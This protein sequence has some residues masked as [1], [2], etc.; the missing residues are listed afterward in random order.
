[1]QVSGPISLLPPLTLTNISLDIAPGQLAAVANGTLSDSP[2]AVSLTSTAVQT[3]NSS[4]YIGVVQLSLV[5][6]VSQGTGSSG[7]TLH[8]LLTS[9]S[10]SITSATGIQLP[11]VPG[12]PANADTSTNA[13][14]KAELVYDSVHGLRLVK[15]SLGAAQMG[16]AELARRMGIDWQ[17]GADGSVDP[18]T[19]RAPSV[20][21]ALA[22]PRAPR[23]MWAGREFGAAAELG[24]SALMDVPSLGVSSA[25]GVLLLQSGFK[26]T[27]Q[28]RAGWELVHSRRGQRHDVWCIQILYLIRIQPH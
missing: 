22:K 18:V 14:T 24:V 16:V 23:L 13:T 5:S 2:V 3:G 12:P 6:N 10:S 21:F 11:A 26:L 15:I 1:M 7:Q 19:F 27:L 17:A 8:G 20:H 25:R 4:R 28:V 9:L